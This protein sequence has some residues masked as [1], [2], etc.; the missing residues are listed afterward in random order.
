VARR[1]PKEQVAALAALVNLGPTSAGWLVAAG[2]TSPARLRT[3]GA[4]EAYR[5]VAWSRGG[6]VTYN[7][8]YALEGAIRGVR[9]DYLPASIRLRLRRRVD[10]D[11]K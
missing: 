11:S 9:W 4:V 10:R 5:R 6:A 1:T 3:L 2:V 8:L 7:L